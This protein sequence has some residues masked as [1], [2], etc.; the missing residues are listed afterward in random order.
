MPGPLGFS[1]ERAGSPQRVDLACCAPCSWATIWPLPLLFF[2]SSLLQWGL[3]FWRYSPHGCLRSR[4]LLRVCPL[5]SSWRGSACRPSWEQDARQKRSCLPAFPAYCCFL[6]Y[7]FLW[8]TGFFPR[9]S[10]TL[11][12][13]RESRGWAGG[14]LEWQALGCTQTDPCPLTC[15]IVLRPK[16]RP[17]SPP[18]MSSFP[19]RASVPHANS[20]ASQSSR[21]DYREGFHSSWKFLEGPSVEETI[22]EWSGEVNKI[23]INK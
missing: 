18:G 8:F 3:L 6:I 11:G 21:Q 17:S 13:R 5:M 19:G 20:A 10:F 22:I 23:Y 14:A 2:P 16:W 15:P 4:P 7:Q 12:P 9:Q 1:G